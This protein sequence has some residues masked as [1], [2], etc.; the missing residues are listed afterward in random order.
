[1][2]FQA[3]DRILG[4]SFDVGGTLVRAWPSVGAVYAS[5]CAESGI[6]LDVETCNARFEE[7]WSRRGAERPAGSDRFDGIPGGEDAWWG[8]LVTEVLEAC[9]LPGAKAPP[10]ESF[11]RAFSSPASWRVFDDVPATLD[12]LGRAGYKLG[13]L[14]N[15]DSRLGILLEALGLSAYFDAVVCSALERREKPAPLIFSR[16]AE[17]LGLDPAEIVHI[18]D[19]ALEDYHGAREAGMHALLIDRSAGAASPDGVP[20]GD[21]VSSISEVGERL[22]RRTPPDEGAA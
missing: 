17:K 20:S 16:A 4:V 9:G 22:L 1:L 18:G 5:V 14:S 3:A 2:S 15:W 8:A 11:R 19:R 21:R 10:I 13:I 6:D 12:A 7:A